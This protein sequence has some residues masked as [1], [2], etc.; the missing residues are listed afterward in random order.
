MNSPSGPMR[1]LLDKNVA[2]YTIAGLRY[3]HLRLLSPLETGALSLWRA[4]EEH[5]VMLFISRISFQ[6]LQRLSGYDEVRIFLDL[7][8]VLSPTRYHTRWA[9]RIRET[10][11]LTRE[12][13]SLVALASFGSDQQGGILGTHRLI[14]YDRSLINSYLNHLP[15]LTRRLRAM[16]T[17]LQAPFHQATLPHLA[18][19]DEILGEWAN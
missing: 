1:Y 10:A 13:A 16:T 2:R 7:V 12:D 4:A 3:G 6:V 8:S 5:G 19:P 11:G 14:T 17:Q 9:R 15:T 18:T